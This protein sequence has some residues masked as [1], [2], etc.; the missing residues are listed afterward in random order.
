LSALALVVLWKRRLARTVDVMHEL[1]TRRA[2]I[3]ADERGA[4]SGMY[5]SGCFAIS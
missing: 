3:A 2:H 4:K 5:Q 1:R